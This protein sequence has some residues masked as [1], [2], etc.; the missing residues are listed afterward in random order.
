MPV[1]EQANQVI[2]TVRNLIVDNQTRQAA[3][4]LCLH[5]ETIGGEQFQTALLL[6][7]RIR[8]LE[9]Q[10]A[11]NTISR[12]DADLEHSRINEALLQ[13]VEDSGKTI[14]N[15]HESSL[16][17]KKM[18]TPLLAAAGLVLVI[19]VFLPFFK[20]SSFDL[21]VMVFEAAG[22]VSEGRVKVKI[23]D[24]I[25]P[26]KPLDSNGKAIFDKILS[27]YLRDSITL[28]LVGMKYRVLRQSAN[29][30]AESQEVTFTVE[31]IRDTATVWG[32]V[33]NEKRAAIAGAI[34]RVETPGGFVTA[35]SDAKGAF[36]IAV[37]DRSEGD[38]AQMT[39]EWEGEI[40]WNQ[41]VTLSKSVAIPV[42][43]KSSGK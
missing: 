30:A 6:Q 8:K 9:S 19:F 20:K 2:E 15:P 1:T 32:I 33:Q 7:G 26:E 34:L 5:F 24:Y 42:L 38:Q 12:E 35:Q 27:E 36:R 22:P 28:L 17:W 13:L 18:R 23:G 16:S 37:P 41:Q 14:S 25:S 31:R 21:R 3:E 39:V 43:L 29:T 4:Y 40:R 11:K 10:I